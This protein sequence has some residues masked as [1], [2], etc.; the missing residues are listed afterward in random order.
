MIKARIAVGKLL[1]QQ[2]NIVTLV[3]VAGLEMKRG[4]IWDTLGIYSQ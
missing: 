4:H 3:R 1:F 2:K